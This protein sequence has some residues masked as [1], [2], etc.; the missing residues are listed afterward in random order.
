[1]LKI[2]F[3][4]CWVPPIYS[5][6]VY[7]LLLATLARLRAPGGTDRFS[8]AGAGAGTDSASSGNDGPAQPSV[9]IMIPAHDEEQV[10]ESKIAN[11]LLLDYP[12]SRL[13]IFVLSDG[14]T[15]RTVAKA[16]EAARAHPGETRIA[17]I[18]HP[19]RRGKTA[20]LNE[21]VPSAS[22]EII[23]HT[24]ANAILAPDALRWIVVPFADPRVGC[25]VGELLYTNT[26]EP[27]VA[28]GEGL[29]WRYENWIKE[30]E[31]R[32]GSTITANGGIYALRRRM[33]EPLPNHIAG[34]AA[35]PLIIARQGFKVLFERRARAYERAASTLLEEFQRKSRIITQGIAAYFWVRGLLLPPRPWP[36]FELLSHKLLRWTVP[37]CLLC[38]LALN[39]PLASSPLFALSLAGQAAFYLL[40]AVGVARAAREERAG[41]RA[42]QDA[43]SFPARL[44]LLAGYFCVVNTAA[45]AGMIDFA[46][47]VR[48]PMWEKSPSTRHA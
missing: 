44:A 27:A 24:D 3:L 32:L 6:L 14:S 23:V 43:A 31:S 2:L 46:R 45:I 42:A 17:V 1:M 34:D 10:I 15:D 41:Q 47:G 9:T 33:F 7:P 18:D 11:C 40:A 21:D 20:C 37:L 12:P 19:V 22:G 30:N 8:A 4:A 39:L 26:A 35:D 28:G 25:V 5:Y 48:R 36:A 16:R 13:E 29:Y 38:A